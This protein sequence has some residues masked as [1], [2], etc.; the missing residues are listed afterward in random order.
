LA[1]VEVAY[2]NS[3]HSS[4][5]MAPFEAL[6]G[7]YYRSLVGLFDFS[8]LRPC[9]KDFLQEALD[10]GW[11]IQ[12]R[13]RSSQTMHKSYADCRCRPSGYRVGDRVFL[14]VSPMKDMV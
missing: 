6:Y 13:I 10:S 2:N 8:V 12:D 4:I 14:R 1:L 9:G 7:R 5:Q 11:V 3:Y